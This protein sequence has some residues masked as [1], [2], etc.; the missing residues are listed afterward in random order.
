M[1]N[2]KLAIFF[3]IYIFLIGV[4]FLN[5]PNKNFSK[6]ENRYLSKA[7]LINSNDIINGNFEKSFS[8]FVADQF[9]FR[10]FWIF[11]KTDF[12]I[13]LGSKESHEVYLSKDKRL[14]EKFETPKKDEIIIRAHKILEI[15]KKFSNAQFVVATMPTSGEIYKEDLPYKNA[16]FGDEKKS[17]DDFYI[18][19]DY[20]VKTVDVNYKMDINKKENIYY[21][22]DHHWTTKGAFLAYE[23]ICKA[24][25]IDS[26][27]EN[28]FKK[29]LVSKD[30]KGSLSSKSGFR[31]IE[32][33]KI[34]RMD[35]N[36]EK[37]DSKLFKEREETEFSIYDDSKL[38]EK[39][40]YA[41]FL[42]G[43]YAY[44]KIINNNAKIKEPILIVKDSY[45]NALIPFLSLHYK[46]IILVD[47]RY[48][49][50]NFTTIMKKEKPSKVLFLNNVKTFFEDNSLVHF[51]SN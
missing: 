31:N 44:A 28:D 6:Q 25:N 23:E 21:K 35:F 3:L 14:I 2:N 20:S 47:P 32:K 9:P 19:F 18:Q 42:G 15:A 27:K 13:L 36:G 46:K 51:L 41:Y 5:N 7:P 50:E 26:K 16:P 22:T 39:D 33:E 49:R 45:A 38:K 24:L 48:E 12:Q 10:D 8:E 29:I 4:F 1:K 40:K 30:F 34:F 37:L 17:I 43:N 11:L